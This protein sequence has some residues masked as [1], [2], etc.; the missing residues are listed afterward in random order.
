MNLF[1]CNLLVHVVDGLLF[2][3]FS[4]C[5]NSIFVFLYQSN[6]KVIRK[7]CNLLKKYSS[8]RF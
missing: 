6:L 8:T 3:L 1:F 5:T 7:D 2:L 4:P